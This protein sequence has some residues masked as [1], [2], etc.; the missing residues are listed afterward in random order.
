MDMKAFN[1][2]LI[3]EFRANGGKVTGRFAD[4]PLLLL[5]T[6][7]ARS[8][9]PRT[10]PLVYGTSGEDI[11]VIASKAGADSHPDWYRNLLANPDVTV[12]L[13]GD[14]FKAR[15][16]VT[17]GGE[18]EQLYAKQAEQFPNFA[19]YQQKTERQIPV[20]VLD[21]TG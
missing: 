15:A 8:G 2:Q 12:E 3:A 7:G 16:R 9:Q 11:F 5:T 19:E 21:R 4:S 17:E 20:V 18:R 14:T 1:E 10:S 13:P 6:T